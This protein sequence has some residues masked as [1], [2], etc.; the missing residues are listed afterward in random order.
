MTNATRGT[1]EHGNAPRSIGRIGGVA[2]SPK[3][4]LARR[5]GRGILPPRA[6][7]MKKIVSVS[8][9]ALRRRVG[10]IYLCTIVGALLTEEPERPR[11]SGH[12][13]AS[14]GCTCSGVRM[15][16]VS[17]IRYA[18]HGSTEATFPA[19]NAD[20]TGCGHR[21][22]FATFQAGRRST[23]TRQPPRVQAGSTGRSASRGRC[24]PACVSLTAI[25]A[26][27]RGSPTSGAPGHTWTRE[28]GGIP[29]LGTSSSKH[30]SALAAWPRRWWK[31]REA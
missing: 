3:G 22:G 25:N 9:I 24:R 16:P 17:M 20:Q 12:A 15:V 1:V 8:R 11:S 2:V 28:T 31:E 21:S 27:S 19:L 5:A 23:Q 10:H 30:A 29:S 4:C 13:P 6:S 14:S 7:A 26:S 18:E